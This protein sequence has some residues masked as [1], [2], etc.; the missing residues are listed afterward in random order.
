[1]LFLHDSVNLDS[2]MFF[3]LIKVNLL[4]K[5]VHTQTNHQHIVKGFVKLVTFVTLVS[6]VNDF[7]YYFGHFDLVVSFGQIFTKSH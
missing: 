1:M 7:C 2:I 4:K 5:Y 6:S 3:S